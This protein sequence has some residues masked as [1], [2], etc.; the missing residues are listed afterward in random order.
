MLVS[1]RALTVVIVAHDD[2]QSSLAQSIGF[3]ARLRCIVVFDDG[4]TDDTLAVAK[5]T[6]SG[7]ISDCR[8]CRCSG[9][10]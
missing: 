10:S 3:T 7:K 1:A 5:A 9:F 2:S 8:S 4:S 6:W